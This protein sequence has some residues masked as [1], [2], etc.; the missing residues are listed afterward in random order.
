[1]RKALRVVVA[2]LTAY[3]LQATVLP[4][5]KINGVMLDLV[6]ITLCSIGFAAGPYVGLTAGLFGA[7]LLEVLGGDLSGYTAVYCIVAGGF[8]AWIA[9]RVRNFKRVGNR[10]LEKLVK[11]FAPMVAF[12]VFELAKETIY[13]IYFYLTGVDIVFIHIFR[14]L[15]AGLE[16]MLFSLVLMPLIR[17]FVLRGPE[18]TLLAKWLR[19][20]QAKSGPKP[21]E[22]EMTPAGRETSK[23]D[24]AVVIT[25]AEGGTEP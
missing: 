11:R 7:L 25:P 18:D 2:V 6:S 17:G 8:G 24:G 13:V 22:P 16:T 23:E 9:I 19:K 4:Y 3:L 20:R 1:M 15:I 10:A 12:G 5:F 14:V 21:L